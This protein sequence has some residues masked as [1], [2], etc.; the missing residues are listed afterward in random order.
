MM[1]QERE[2]SLPV[3]PDGWTWEAVVSKESVTVCLVND[4]VTIASRQGDCTVVQRESRIYRLAHDLWQDMNAAAKLSA[5][6]GIQ[7]IYE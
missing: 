7:V 5:K 3:L 1:A 6:L 2:P 4:G